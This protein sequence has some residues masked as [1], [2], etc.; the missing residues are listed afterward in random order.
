MTSISG[1]GTGSTTATQQTTSGSSQG[2]SGGAL[3]SSAGIGSGL[4]VD[5]IVAALVNAKQAGPA[6]QIS[7]QTTQLQAQEAGLTALNGALASLQSALGKLTATGTFSSYA[8][9]LSNSAVG[10]ASTLPNAQPG[11]Y[12]VV[13]DHLATAQKRAS[14]SYAAGADVGGGTLTIGVGAASMDVKVSDAGSI[15]DLAA[16][17][18]AG[19]DNP[20]VQA[21]VVHGANGSQ[22]LLTSTRTGVANAFT[23]S[24]SADSSDGLAALAQ[25]LDTAGA[26]EASDASLSIDGIAV[27]SA[28]NAVSG[29]LNGVTL[30]L[31]TT[32]TTTLTVSRD[33]SA[34]QSAVAGFVSAYN[35]Y[36][37][38]VGTLSSY[39]QS[40]RQAGVLLGDTT[41]MSVQRQINSVLSGK[42]TGNAIGSLAALGIKRGADGTLTLDSGK[43]DSAL[44]GNPGAVQ[45]LFAGGNGYA[46]K[47]NS[48]LNGFTGSGGIIATRIASI[49][50]RLGGLGQQS[51]AL[52]ARMNVYAAQLRQQYTALDTLM[53][54]L[55]NT[56]SYLTGAL[57]QL[58]A[59]YTGSN[60]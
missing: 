20:G 9:T 26:S 3:L 47:L 41:L 42:V 59:T 49:E 27:S 4:K 33:N 10:T 17:I 6:Q 8:A 53:S 19:K 30:N 35:S 15:S 22:L 48:A 44:N 50:K 58:E 43:L 57:K 24:A 7:G 46:T 5:D 56:S 31:A 38:T 25:A 37:S 13:V 21:T 36:V 52:T 23:V 39:D 18:N 55:N 34:A 12:T 60:K 16:A 32:G 28:S 2:I 40:T 54:S 45:D 11:S 14:G 51:A 29:A 1:L